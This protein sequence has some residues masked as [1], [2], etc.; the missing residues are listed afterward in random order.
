M[1]LR[2]ALVAVL[3]PVV[4]VLTVAPGGPAHAVRPEPSAARASIPRTYD[5]ALQH[6]GNAKG[7]ERA[8]K[9][10]VTPSGN[11]Y[12]ALKVKGIPT[13]CELSQGSIKDPDAC[14]GNPVSDR[15][16]RVE[17]HGGRAVPICNTDTI[18]TPGARTLRYGDI[19]HIPGWHYACLSEEIGVTCINENK[20][21]GFFLHRGE[22]VIFN[23][24]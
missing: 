9:K 15:V 2:R 10:F 17:F 7:I 11:I 13:G 21:E 3:V 22:Y 18:R 16:G 23:A 1:S 20:A 5:A 8:Y 4:A 12:C 6:F 19:A 24:G 14:P